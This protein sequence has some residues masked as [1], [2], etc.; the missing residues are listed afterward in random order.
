MTSFRQRFV[1]PV[2]GAVLLS[3]KTTAH[4]LTAGLFGAT[5]C[6]RKHFELMSFRVVVRRS[7]RRQRVR[8]EDRDATLEE[9]ASGLLAFGLLL[10]RHATKLPRTI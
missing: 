7:P 10:S 9:G 2:L 6:D 4:I 3:H 8:V 5:R 1:W